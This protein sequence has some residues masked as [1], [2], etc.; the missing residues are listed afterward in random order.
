MLIFLISDYKKNKKK[1]IYYLFVFYDL[2]ATRVIP[3]LEET[4]MALSISTRRGESAGSGLRP[5]CP[6]IA[7]PQVQT[8]PS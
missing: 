3:S 4:E 8:V 7:R 5:S 6:R 2:T 1:G